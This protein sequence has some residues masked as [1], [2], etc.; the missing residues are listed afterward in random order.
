MK[1]EKFYSQKLKKLIFKLNYKKAKRL[2]FTNLISRDI[3]IKKQRSNKKQ[4]AKKII[5]KK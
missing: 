3:K 1:K 2:V 5:R 4:R